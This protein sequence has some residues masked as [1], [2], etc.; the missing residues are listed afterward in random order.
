MRLPGARRSAIIVTSIATSQRIAWSL[1]RILQLPQ[2]ILRTGR[3]IAARLDSLIHIL[4]TFSPKLHASKQH[5]LLSC[6]PSSSCHPRTVRLSRR[7]PLR[8]MSLSFTSGL[9]RAHQFATMFL[10]RGR[11][12][13][14]VVFDL[15]YFSAISVPGPDCTVSSL[16]KSLRQS[17]FAWQKAEYFKRNPTSM[18]FIPLGTFIWSRVV[19]GFQVTAQKISFFFSPSW[20]IL[21]I[22]IARTCVNGVAKSISTPR[23]YG[24]FKL[25][26][27]QVI[28]TY[29]KRGSQLQCYC[30]IARR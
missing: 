9:A 27:S 26:L 11:L 15:K 23:D 21:I 24:S 8:H 22:P 28:S 10:T 29:I 16:H 14:G 20:Q 4:V 2:E 17:Q 6:E 7:N 18:P 13:L 30:Q 19:L 12:F 1:A 25:Y 5:Q 3:R